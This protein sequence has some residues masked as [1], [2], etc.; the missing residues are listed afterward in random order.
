M[1]KNEIKMIGSFGQNKTRQNKMAIQMIKP[2]NQNKTRQRRMKIQ[3]IRPFDQNK[4]RQ[5]RMKIPMIKPLDQE[6]S[7]N[8]SSQD[9]DGDR[10]SQG[11]SL[12]TIF[13]SLFIST[14]RCSSSRNSLRGIT[15]STPSIQ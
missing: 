4:T 11:G 5:R 10:R 6:K 14:A 7:S 13:K 15:H 8:N 1:I 12:V 3:M 9:Q 2:F